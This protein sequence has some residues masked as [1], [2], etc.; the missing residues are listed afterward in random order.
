MFGPLT[1]KDS[2]ND[3]ESSNVETQCHIFDVH[4]CVIEDVQHIKNLPDYITYWKQRFK[5]SPVDQIIP[6]VKI[7][8]TDEKYFLFSTLLKE[9][10]ELRHKLTLDF[11]IKVQ[12][13]ERKD[14]HFVRSCLLCKLQF[15]GVF[16]ERSILKEH[17]RKKL[18][19]RTN[20]E[21]SQY[22]KFYIINYLEI[23]KTWKVLQKESDKYA[24]QR[25]VEENS[26]PEYFDWNEPTVDKITCLFC[27]HTETDIN[28]LCNHM[29]FKHR[30]NFVQSTKTL[31]FY[32][33]VKLINYIRK[34]VHNHVCPY[35]ERNFEIQIQLDHHMEEEQHFKIPKVTKFDQPEFYFP[36][37]ENDTFLYLIDDMETENVDK[38][39]E[40]L[41]NRLVLIQRRNSL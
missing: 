32:Q 23:G 19:K 31:N 15:E 13:Y 34:T 14:E 17:M 5:C 26:D 1:F 10:L 18:H 36:T 29:T 7:N 33:K 9:D 41:S 20:S 12:E 37:Y 35:C 2:I 24:I 38:Q 16:P 39:K 28:I 8:K 25:G 40:K 21:D 30:F 6:S 22:D 27:C 11:V 3:I 4:K